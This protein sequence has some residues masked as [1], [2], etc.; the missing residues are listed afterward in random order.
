M[1]IAMKDALI[2]RRNWVAETLEAYLSADDLEYSLELYDDGFS[3]LEAFNSDEFCQ[4][5]ITLMPG[6]VFTEETH[7]AILDDLRKVED[8]EEGMATEDGL[9]LAAT[10]E[11][12]E[13]IPRQNTPVTTIPPRPHPHRPQSR[14]DPRKPTLL[15][16]AY[17]HEDQNKQIEVVVEDLSRSGVGMLWFT[18]DSLA[19]GEILSLQFDLDDLRHTV[20]EASVC[21]RWVKDDIFGVQFVEPDVLPQT[22]FDYLEADG[23]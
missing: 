23:F 13:I 10:G 2:Q 11:P 7:D 8:S 21:V 9:T 12:T 16:G 18:P 19:I 22:F 5:L 3:T 20:V 14:R 6:T 4:C 15:M 1:G 17:R